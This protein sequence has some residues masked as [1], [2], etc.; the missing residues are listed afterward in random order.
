MTLLP[1]EEFSKI[2]HMLL[3]DSVFTYDLRLITYNSHGVAVQC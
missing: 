1:D 2:L 3:F